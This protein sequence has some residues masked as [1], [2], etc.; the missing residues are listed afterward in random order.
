M[1]KGQ[2]RMAA[3]AIAALQAQHFDDSQDDLFRLG[4]IRDFVSHE[5]IKLPN[6]KGIAIGK[7]EVN[8]AEIEGLALIVFVGQKLSLEKLSVDDRIPR[9]LDPFKSGAFPTD[10]IE[11][12][13]DDDAYDSD[14]SRPSS[15]R[16]GG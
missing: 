14:N 11:W 5:L 10:V 15:P 13:D 12:P 4:A 6:V 8:G 3:S 2:L 16:G 7:K 1:G 9:F